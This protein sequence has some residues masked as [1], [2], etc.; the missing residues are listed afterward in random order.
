MGTIP[1]SKW[2]ILRHQLGKVDALVA[3]LKRHRA[4]KIWEVWKN[5]NETMLVAI[6]MALLAAGAWTYRLVEG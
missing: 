6:L 4:R 5:H 1:L 3:T 2:Q